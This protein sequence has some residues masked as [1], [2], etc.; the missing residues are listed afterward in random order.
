MGQAPTHTPA[1]AIMHTT[2]VKLKVVAAA[3]IQHETTSHY[4][5]LQVS[6]EQQQPSR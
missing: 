4:S 5:K 6:A 3:Q 2:A 1:T